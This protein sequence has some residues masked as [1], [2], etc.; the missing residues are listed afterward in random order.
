MNIK[1]E[2]FDRDLFA[3]QAPNGRIDIYRKVDALKRAMVMEEF[4]P[5]MTQLIISLTDTW[6]ASGTPVEWG[7]DS[8][9]DRLNWMDSWKDDGMFQRMRRNREREEQITRNRFKNEARAIA[10][11]MRKD[12]AK[13]TNDLRMGD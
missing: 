10:A 1:L 5:P 4:Q 12:F 13:A 8:I 3:M 11:D 6:M 7:I 9:F 2:K